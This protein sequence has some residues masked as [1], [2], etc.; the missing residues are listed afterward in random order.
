M[1]YKN[2]II[3]F[4]KGFVRKAGHKS[5]LFIPVWGAR[6]H[7][8]GLYNA[9]LDSNWQMAVHWAT[10]KG[11]TRI[12]IL[13]PPREKLEG[14][15]FMSKLIAAAE[16]TVTIYYSRAYGENAS[17]TR[18]STLWHNVLHDWPFAKYNDIFVS[19]QSA[20][21][22]LSKLSLTNVYYWAYAIASDNFKPD[23]FEPFIDIDRS[24]YKRMPM[25]VATADQAA[26]YPKAIHD[27]EMFNE[28]LYIISTDAHKNPY[29][30]KL[31]D[32][33]VYHPW[34]Q[35]HKPYKTEMLYEVYSA[36]FGLGELDLLLY[37]APNDAI[38]A[39]K[40]PAVRVASD[41][42]S[43]YEIISQRPTIIALGDPDL[44]LHFAYF[45]Y[46]FRGC[47]MYLPI[48]SFIKT[49]YSLS[50]TPTKAELLKIWLK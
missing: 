19:P 34:R 43:F 18:M 2:H 49:K 39:P 47:K 7:A 21:Y 41:K 48:N 13:A 10:N 38:T 40:M 28:A 14:L 35:S 5:A 15:E 11:Y 6:S 30:Y 27:N 31:P 44:T 50:K 37:T 12:A 4:T 23:Y 29:K 20:A 3:N 32:N 46:A 17:T 26:T 45:E 1:E 33:I 36:A 8:S 9:E 22:T 42:Q 16:L 24:L 25:I